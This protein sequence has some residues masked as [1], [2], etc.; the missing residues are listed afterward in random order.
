MSTLAGS[1]IRRFREERALS[2]AAFG[3]WF[4]TPGSTVQGWEEEGKRASSAIANQIA[5][6]G[7]AHHADWHVNARNS[8]DMMND[9]WSPD[10]WTG[11]AFEARQLPDYPDAAALKSATDTISSFPPLVFAGE[12]RN[13]TG[14]LARVSEGRAF[15][16]QGG[17]CAEASPN[18]I[19]TISATRS[20][21]SF[22]WR[23]C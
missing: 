1:K 21:S 10:S 11:T 19:P 18:F 3:A 22:R 2:R 4:N 6:N 20:A 12:A 8:G 9:S 7:I 13:L 17:D 14:D 5:A 15:L 16:L 23:L